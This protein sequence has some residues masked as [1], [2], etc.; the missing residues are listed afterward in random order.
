MAPK[1]GKKKPATRS[2]RGRPRRLN[3]VTT[4]D[5]QAELERREGNIEML[6]DQRDSLLAE[7]EEVEN[8]MVA[9]TGSVKG[10]LKPVTGKG[11]A[12]YS[13]RSRAAR[14]KGGLSLADTLA[15]VLNGKTLSVTEAAEAVKKVGYGSRSPNLRTMVNQQLIGDKGRFKRVSRGQYTVK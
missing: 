1:K 14:Q 12:A 11:T 4:K 8:E 10:G 6:Q 13:L 3:A 5:L 2:R 7:L 15:K 9:L